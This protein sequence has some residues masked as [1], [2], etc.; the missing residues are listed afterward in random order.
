M[1]S[2]LLIVVAAAMMEPLLL[3]AE[4]KH[5]QYITVAA[6]AAILLVCVGDVDH[7]IGL[8]EK[9]IGDLESFSKVLL[10]VA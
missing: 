3:T 4:K 9:T 8:G 7:L 6:G 5:G 1:T 2:V 10:P